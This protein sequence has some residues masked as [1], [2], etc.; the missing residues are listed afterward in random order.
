[1]S[2]SHQRHVLDG[3]Q[4]YALCVLYRSLEQVSQHIGAKIIVIGG[5][6]T[7]DTCSNFKHV[8]GTH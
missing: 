3:P 8:H 4:A 7:F 6:L 2:S 1:M 5:Q